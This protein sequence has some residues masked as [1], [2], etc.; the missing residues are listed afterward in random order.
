M[1]MSVNMEYNTSLP[2]VTVSNGSLSLFLVKLVFQYGSTV[3]DC[4]AIT[5][6]IIAIVHIL[7]SKRERRIMY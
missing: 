5:A 2:Q 4:I 7:L 1:Q 3:C 6:W